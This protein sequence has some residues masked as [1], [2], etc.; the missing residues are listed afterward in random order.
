M[1]VPASLAWLRQETWVNGFRAGPRAQGSETRPD[2]GL[3]LL[4]CLPQLPS[5]P[6]PSGLSANSPP[7]SE[8]E[9][10]FAGSHGDLGPHLQTLSYRPPPL[11]VLHPQAQSLALLTTVA[12]PVFSKK[13]ETVSGCS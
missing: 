7:H 2:S 13:N 9:S 11:T 12:M 1:G 4:W 5:S 6:F 8:K 3:C 10:L